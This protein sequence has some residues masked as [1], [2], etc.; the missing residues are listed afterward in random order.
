MR[1]LPCSLIISV[2][3]I[4]VMAAVTMAN[5]DID[6]MVLI[7]DPSAIR[8]GPAPP[9]LPK[10]I[11]ISILAGDPGKAGSFVLRVRAPAN[12]TIA[13]H[14]HSAAEN[15]T[16]IS[17]VLFHGMGNTL[18]KAQG[19]AVASGGFVYLPANMP[20]SVWTTDEPAEIQV[21][22]TGPFAVHY[23]NAA[24]DPSNVR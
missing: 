4:I 13:P 1:L 2:T 9:S 6:Q 3:V 16:V 17:G 12:S 19:H 8:W 7:S 20:H 23:V 22:G 15:L 21:S 11:Q 10:G 18:D 24:D 14:T 5:D